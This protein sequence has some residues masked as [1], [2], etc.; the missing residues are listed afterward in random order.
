[1]TMKQ[2]L[3]SHPDNDHIVAMNESFAEWMFEPLGNNPSVV[4]N[5]FPKFKSHLEDGL[6][7][8]R[9]ITDTTTEWPYDGRSVTTEELFQEFLKTY[10]P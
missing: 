8:W 2:W 5:Y 4:D 10:T 3:D 6:I 1:M 7:M 9:R